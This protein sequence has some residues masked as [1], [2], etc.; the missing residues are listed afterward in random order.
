MVNV[1]K[2]NFHV[3]K[4]VKIFWIAKIIIVK[5]NVIKSNKFNNS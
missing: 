5:I 3:I 4:Y 2:V 1:E